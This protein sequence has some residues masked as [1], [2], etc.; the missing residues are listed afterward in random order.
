[1]VEYMFLCSLCGNIFDNNSISQNIN[2][3]QDLLN[4]PKKLDLTVCVGCYNLSNYTYLM[5][6]DKYLII[7]KETKL[8]I[9]KITSTTF[10]TKDKKKDIEDIVV[11]NDISKVMKR[12]V[13][14]KFKDF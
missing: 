3:K 5:D 9:Y 14:N 10:E 11:V 1:M 12:N 2:I 7:P 6:Y 8:K 4:D 13:K